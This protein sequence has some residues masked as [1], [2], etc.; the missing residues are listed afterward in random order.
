MNIVKTLHYLSPHSQFTINGDDPTNAD[1]YAER[2]DWIA[3]VGEQPSW[4]DVVAASQTVADTLAN[5]SARRARLAAFRD[6]ADPLFF[7]W[8][9][10]ENTEQEWLDKC[11]EIRQRFPYVPVPS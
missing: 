4:A 10:G 11:E 7:G 8:Q 1:E 2:V 9:R 6:E 3:P 5:E